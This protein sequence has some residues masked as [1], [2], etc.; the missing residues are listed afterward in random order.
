MERQ[1]EPDGLLSKDLIGERVRRHMPRVRCCRCRLC[2][3]R[4]ETGRL[5][6]PH[7]PIGSDSRRSLAGVEHALAALVAERERKSVGDLV[8]S[9]RAEMAIIGHSGMVGDC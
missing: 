2:F 5:E 7:K 3:H 6:M 1:V 4:H 8:R 9:G